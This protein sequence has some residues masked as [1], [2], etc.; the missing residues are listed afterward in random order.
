MSE[1]VLAAG[2]DQAVIAP[3]QGAR[4]AS[5]VA[6]RCER[7]VTQAASDGSPSGWGIF[8]MAPWAGR[9]ADAVIPFRGKQYPVR[10]NLG[11][12]GIHGVVFDK[13]WEIRRAT[14]S[15]CETMAIFDEA[16]WPFGGRI[17]QRI[18]LE[19]GRL[20]LRA[21]IEAG[22]EPMPLS[23]G[24]HPWFRR[25]AEADLRIALAADHIL[26]TT[27]DLIP[28]GETISVE[29]ETDLSDGPLLGTRRLDTVYVDPARHALV[30][31]PDLSL[32]IELPEPFTTFVVYTPQ[33]AACVE[34]Q[35]A[36]PNAPALAYHG[37]P[38]T[39]LQILEA[40]ESFTA[41]TSL[42]WESS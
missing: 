42:A 41:S 39:G 37:V 40:G 11:P 19:P 22:D 23:M 38:G 25:P 36:W 32:T 29:G 26:V 10:Q 13:A 24:W 34:P 18:T 1:I 31:W 28:T 7:L 21:D 33:G 20:H 3:E 16:E 15:S 5:L 8:L 12:H 2:E 17:I 4:I 6:N 35:T 30:R 9:V 14:E 27:E